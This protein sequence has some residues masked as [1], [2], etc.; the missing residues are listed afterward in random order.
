[1]KLINVGYNN[2]VLVSRVIA[3]VDF[4]SAP[5]KRIVSDARENH[6]LI[7][8]TSG[9]KTRTVII[10]DSDH[11]VLSAVQRETMARRIEDPNDDIITDIIDDEELLDNE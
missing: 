10:M 3:M 2:M 9:R 6:R 7:D 5:I 8:A 4:D 1:M 11:I